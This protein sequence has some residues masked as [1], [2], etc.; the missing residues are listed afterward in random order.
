ME[1]EEELF[2]DNMEDETKIMIS[3]LWREE[4]LEPLSQNSEG[5][6]ARF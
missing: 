1:K 6:P 2:R 5:T 4:F 3:N